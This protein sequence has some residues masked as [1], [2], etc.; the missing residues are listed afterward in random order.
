M[1]RLLVVSTLLLGVFLIPAAVADD[2]ENPPSS[3]DAG[4]PADPG[5]EP[6]GMPP[7][8][9]TQGEPDEAPEGSQAETP[10]FTCGPTTDGSAQ[11]TD[12]GWDQYEQA[13][14]VTVATPR[15]YMG[16][17]VGLYAAFGVKCGMELA[18]DVLDCL[19][20]SENCPALPSL[21]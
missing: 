19:T 21:P 16:P 9:Q 20:A 5:S 6:A 13:A 17:H 2:A 14:W 3:D 4:A 12:A 8:N 15:G 18:Q 7:E 11:F 1:V 10:P